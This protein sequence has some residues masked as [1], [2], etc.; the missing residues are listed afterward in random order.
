MV[1]MWAIYK[2]WSHWPLIKSNKIACISNRCT[3][4]TYLVH[5]GDLAWY[6]GFTLKQSLHEQFG[7]WDGGR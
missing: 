6:F 2:R 4:V 5:L 7:G 1:D 3:L